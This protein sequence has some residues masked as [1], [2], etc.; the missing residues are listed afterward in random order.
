MFLCIGLEAV[1]MG[2]DDPIAGNCQNCSKSVEIVIEEGKKQI[3]STF[4]KMHVFRA[5]K[6]LDN[7][8]R[9]AENIETKS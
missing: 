2:K 1:L 8:K 3:Y 9:L 6:G 5:S 7:R 4:Q